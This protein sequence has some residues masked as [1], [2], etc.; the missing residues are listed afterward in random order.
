VRASARERNVVDQLPAVPGPVL[1]HRH[2]TCQPGP[3]FGTFG[4]R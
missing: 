1:R 4:R 2:R 3:L